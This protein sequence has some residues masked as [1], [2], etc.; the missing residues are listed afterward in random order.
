M[1]E[2]ISERPAAIPW[3]PLL[4]GAAI[5]VAVVLEGVH[6][7]AWPG[8]N[9]LAAQTIGYG[10]GLVGVGLSA[11]GVLTLLRAHTNILPHKGADRL[12]THGAFAFRRNPLYMGETLM[13]LGLAQTT[14]NF[15]LVLMAPLF[16]AAVLWFAILPEERHLEA[17]FG[18]DYLDY[19]ERTR[20]WF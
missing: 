2:E 1:S 20:R 3:P 6:P 10:L 17:R 4:F 19:K 11:W 8:L 12:I 7:L 5:V 9:D 18:R 13:L 15:W 16:A 14:A